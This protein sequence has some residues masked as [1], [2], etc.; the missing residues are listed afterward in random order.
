M[1]KKLQ[2]L[3]ENIKKNRALYSEHHN[4][5]AQALE[6]FKASDDVYTYNHNVAASL[7]EQ[8][9]NLETEVREIALAEFAINGDKHPHEKVDVKIFTEAVV[10]NADEARAWAFENLPAALKLDDSKVKKYAKEFGEVPGVTIK[11]EPRAQ[12][13]TQL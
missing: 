3:L 6:N 2:S 8:I 12:I 1:N 13:A 10:E 7:I 5:A 4:T 9:T 11:T